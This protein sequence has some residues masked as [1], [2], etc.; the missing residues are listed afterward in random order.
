MIETYNFLKRTITKNWK[1]KTD[2]EICKYYQV[3]NRDEL[4]AYEYCKHI[5]MLR[6]IAAKYGF[7]IESWELS[8][9]VLEFLDKAMKT[10]K[11]ENNGKFITYAFATIR[12]NMIIKNRYF[13]CQKRSINRNTISYDELANEDESEESFIDTYLEDATY[14]N[15][16]TAILEADMLNNFNLS[17]KEKELCS[18]LL[19]N[20]GV[21]N[22]LEIAEG[23][24]RDRITVYNYTNSIKE[25]LNKDKEY[26]R[27]I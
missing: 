2:E 25:K 12:N 10:F 20:C 11:C 22:K 14:N 23:L 8:S 7:F 26:V 24:G 5:M 6:K 16:E 21:S 17:K 4:L 13:G 15:Y 1:D 19:N 3:T 27:G 18:L 9:Y